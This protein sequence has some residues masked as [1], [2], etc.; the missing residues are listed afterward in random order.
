MKTTLLILASLGVLCLAAIMPPGSISLPAC[1]F[2]ERTGLL[3]YG[4]GSTRALQSL[5]HGE[6][7]ASLHY[8]LL[9]LPTLAWLASLCYFKGRKFSYALAVGICTLFVFM[10]IRN[11][12]WGMDSSIASQPDHLLHVP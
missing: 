6:W 4:C 7:E 1:P 9:L 11:T 10:V 3:C 8:N 2:H 5:L 12:P